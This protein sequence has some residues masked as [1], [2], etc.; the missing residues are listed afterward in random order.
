MDKPLFY[1]PISYPFQQRPIFL[2]F[3]T[4]RLFPC[5]CR[6]AGIKNARELIQLPRTALRRPIRLLGHGHLKF[7]LAH[8]AGGNLILLKNQY[9]IARL[10]DIKALVIGDGGEALHPLLPVEV[11]V[12]GALRLLGGDAR[13]HGLV[14]QF[15]IVRPQHIPEG[16]LPPGLEVNVIGIKLGVCIGPGFRLGEHK[17]QIMVVLTLDLVVNI[18][19]FRQAKAE[20]Y[21]FYSPTIPIT[22]YEKKRS[23]IETALNVR[24]V[25]IESGKDFQHVIIKTVTANKEFP[26]ILMWEN[27]Y[28]SEKESVL[29]LG[30]SQLDKVMTDLK[31]TPHIL[32]GGSSG[33]GKSV[34]LK[35]VIMQCVEKGFEIYI[36]DFKGGVDFYG[37]WKRKCNI[38]TQQEQLINRLEYIVE[39]LNSR[40]QLF[41]DCE[42]ANIEQY[43]KLTDC[44]FHRIVFAC[45]E[46][47]E[48]LDKTGLDKE[49]KVQIAKIESL[50]STI[51]RQGRAFGIH[52]ILATQ[53]PDADI[54]KGQIKNNIDFRICGRA[55]KVLSQ[56]ILDNPDGAEK[57]PKDKQGIFLTNTGVLFKAYYFDDSEW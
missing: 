11:D 13:P 41:I 46:I 53:R 24:I 17:G 16:E 49:S 35:L 37:I 40:K 38:I 22:E 36:A 44:N 27:K 26:Q 52:L 48:L 42:C 47:A 45:D 30:E 25:S 6:H 19:H 12:V 10:I 2:Q 5:L 4:Q 1:G 9:R 14:G 31:V 57:I 15:L 54:L 56:I 29:L 39:E 8:V 21:E 20:V 33:S 34:L 28:L 51:A 55:D 23:D 43:N 32:I 18:D 50:L 7:R 3:Y